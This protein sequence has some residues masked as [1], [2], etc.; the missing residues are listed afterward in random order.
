MW[1]MV[2][3]EFLQ[4]SFNQSSSLPWMKT[5]KLWP[6]DYPGSD[7]ESVLIFFLYRC[8]PWIS[9]LWSAHRC[10]AWPT[11]PT[12]TLSNPGSDLTPLASRTHRLL[13]IDIQWACRGGA[14]WA[15]EGC[16][17][18]SSRY[19]NKLSF[20]KTLELPLQYFLH[21][22]LVILQVTVQL[23]ICFTSWTGEFSPEGVACSIWAWS[24]RQHILHAGMWWSD[25]L[26]SL[27]SCENPTVHAMGL[28]LSKLANVGKKVHSLLVCAWYCIDFILLHTCV[29][30]CVSMHTW[31]TRVQ[32]FL[33]I[34]HRWAPSAHVFVSLS[35]T[36]GL[37]ETMVFVSALLSL[38]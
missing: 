8:P 24:T 35:S 25:S 26:S 10:M 18:L 21:V 15:W 19:I 9:W 20:L 34:K 1:Q 11:I 23:D 27:G 2:L 17:T 29:F 12:L 16:S 33:C 31:L 28:M 37:L 5:K 6:K 7:H 38:K 4:M 3:M 36:I 22:L 32:Y 14:K 30:E 13:H